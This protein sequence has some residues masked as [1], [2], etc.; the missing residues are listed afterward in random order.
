MA[1][2]HAGFVTRPDLVPVV[3]G[4]GAAR[5][6]GVVHGA[7]FTLSGHAGGVRPPDDGDSFPLTGPAVGDEGLTVTVFMD[8]TL[9]HI[10]HTRPVKGSKVNHTVALLKLPRLYLLALSVGPEFDFDA[11]GTQEGRR[12]AGRVLL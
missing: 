10:R 6:A 9:T 2:G 1:A 8:G 3:A 4:F 7:M 5:S 12:S 11:A